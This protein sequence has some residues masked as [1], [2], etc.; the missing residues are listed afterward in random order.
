MVVE[1]PVISGGR[2]AVPTG[3]GLG[4]SLNLDV[5]R[6]HARAGEPFFDE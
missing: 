5:A 6:E 3:P 2:I 1:G 4:V